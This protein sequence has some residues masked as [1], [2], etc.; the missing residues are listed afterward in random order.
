MPK[1]RWEWEIN[2]ESI[3]RE[4]ALTGARLSAVA[5]H[6]LRREESRKR[7]PGL[8]QTVQR[9]QTLC[10]NALAR[11][12][13]LRTL[14]ELDDCPPVVERLQNAHGVVRL[15]ADLVREVGVE[16]PFDIF[17]VGEVAWGYLG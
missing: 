9:D 1:I 16:G 13:A 7:L 17:D 5:A 8:A 11:D 12:T 15:D 6:S 10:T 3:V 4:R 14:D 2:S